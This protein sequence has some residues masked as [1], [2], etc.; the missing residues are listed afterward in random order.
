MLAYQRTVPASNSPHNNLRQWYT[1]VLDQPSPIF[2]Y[3]RKSVL[4]DISDHFTT[5]NTA[6]F[7]LQFNYNRVF[8]LLQ[9][10][11]RQGVILTIWEMSLH[12]ERTSS[13]SR[14]FEF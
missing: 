12:Y 11:M 3:V 14:H 2:V 9:H 1:L 10:L 13:K 4:G 5:I 6:L 8:F 7:Q